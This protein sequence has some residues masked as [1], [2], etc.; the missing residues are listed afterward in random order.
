M[1]T[2]RKRVSSLRNRVRKNDAKL[3]SSAGQG[4]PERPLKA[5]MGQVSESW[6]V[7]GE[8]EGLT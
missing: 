4:R 7:G 1:L 2:P 5:R 8:G 3:N 6:E